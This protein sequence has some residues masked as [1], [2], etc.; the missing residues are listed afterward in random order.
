ML[1]LSLHAKLIYSFLNYVPFEVLLLL[2]ALCTLLYVL[3][4]RI[5]HR[6]FE[7]LVKAVKE[8]NEAQVDVIIR[9]D[10]VDL[11]RLDEEGITPFLRAARCGHYSI[12]LTLLKAGCKVNQVDKDMRSALMIASSMGHCNVV[13]LLIRRGARISAKDGSGNT[14]L[15]I[16]AERG[17]IDI[18]KLLVQRGADMNWKNMLGLSSLSVGMTNYYILFFETTLEVR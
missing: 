18:V 17:F 15:I 12:L 16:A 3:F 5:E 10:V 9:D 8:G 4:I 2:A 11:D 1:Y 13:D 7:R 14:A 6:P